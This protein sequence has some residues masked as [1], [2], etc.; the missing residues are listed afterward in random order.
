MEGLTIQYKNGKIH[1]VRS[2][3]DALDC[4]QQHTH[5]TLNRS[6]LFWIEPH[7]ASLKQAPLAISDLRGLIGERGLTHD[8]RR[9]GDQRIVEEIGR[10]LAL[11]HLTAVGCS[12]RPP[13]PGATVLIDGARFHV[14]LSIDQAADCFYQRSHR[15]HE[16]SDSQ[17]TRNLMRQL[18]SDS[19][20]MRD[21]R[22]FVDAHENTKDL[23]SYSDNTAFTELMAELIASHQ[24]LLV[25]CSTSYFTY[26]GAVSEE[27]ETRRPASRK[28]DSGSGSSD[29]KVDEKVKTWIE[30]KL[31]DQ[32]GKPVANEKYELK[33]PDGTLKQGSL[34]AQGLA[35]VDEL[36]PGT[37]TVCFPEIDRREW[38]PV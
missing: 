32:D 7:L 1:L 27:Q 38:K 10:L 9:T 12:L 21:V 17:A 5:I 6:D 31:V 36:D 24:L 19:E 14:V 29:D 18:A 35:R 25:E 4:A 8:L 11:G 16:S 26:G 33:L 13:E 34:D 30:I 23:A 15:I 22:R 37:C 3:R 2:V 20:G 28:A